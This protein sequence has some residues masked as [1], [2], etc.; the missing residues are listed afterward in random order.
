M[1]AE[2]IRICR[3]HGEEPEREAERWLR[4]YHAWPVRVVERRATVDVLELSR[5]GGGL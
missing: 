1:P 3:P 2:S 5:D 4:A